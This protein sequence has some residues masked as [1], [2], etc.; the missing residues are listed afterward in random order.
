MSMVV[1]KPT[2]AHIRRDAVG[3]HQHTS[4]KAQQVSLV[5]LY[6]SLVGL[7][8]SLVGLTLA[9]R[10]ISLRV[11]RARRTLLAISR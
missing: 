5:E 2:L 1:S 7:Y 3:M 11:V 10:E 4:R 8:L 9:V 6:F